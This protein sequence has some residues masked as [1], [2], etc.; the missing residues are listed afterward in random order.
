V[1]VRGRRA[2]ARPE[3]HAVPA[4]GCRAPP[5][6]RARVGEAHEQ[7]D[8]LR[9]SSPCRP[10]RAAA[11]ADAPAGHVRVAGRRSAA[12]SST[13]A[14]AAAVACSCTISGSRG[15]KAAPIGRGGRGTAAAGRRARWS[16]EEDETGVRRTLGGCASRDSCGPAGR[17]RR[18]DGWLAR[19]RGASDSTDSRSKIR[20]RGGSVR[21][22]QSYR[23]K[24]L[25]P[26]GPRAAG[27]P[28][29]ASR[30]VRD[31]TQRRAEGPPPLPPGIPLTTA[32]A[33][34]QPGERLPHPATP[35]QRTSRL[36][37]LPAL[38]LTTSAAQRRSLTVAR[39]V[40]ADKSAS[41]NFTPASGRIV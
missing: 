3:Q 1:L 27:G 31:A 38:Q 21:M 15:M 10:G 28:A 18:R 29:R 23:R 37:S 6:R 32:L 19:A 16:R 25:L 17:R 24:G 34:Q 14:R 9:W 20:A 40:A 41:V 7:H 36:P 5:A 13:A 12:R 4:P 30:R 39:S 11:G 2:R 8:G 22:A 33:R 35:S 26:G